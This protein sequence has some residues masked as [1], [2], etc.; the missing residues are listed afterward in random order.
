[1]PGRLGRLAV[2]Q[3]L[4]NHS[5]TPSLNGDSSPRLQGISAR[6]GAD[7]PRIEGGETTGAGPEAALAVAVGKRLPLGRRTQPSRG[8]PPT[9][10]DATGGCEDRAEGARVSRNASR[11]QR[12]GAERTQPEEAV[13]RAGDR[14]E[15]IVGSRSMTLVG[16]PGQASRR[17][18]SRRQASR[19]QASRR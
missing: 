10:D 12:G 1:M 4:A 15:N 3:E 8:G 5:V 18:P 16:R 9:N 7:P 19:R 6:L 11:A 2:D 17:Q 14:E 13:A